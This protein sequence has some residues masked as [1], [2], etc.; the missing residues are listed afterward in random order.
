MKRNMMDS[1]VAWKKDA[2][3]RPLLLCGAR[4]VG[5][6]WLMKE[7][8]SREYDKTAY[9][10]FDR[11]SP[12]REV[13]ASETNVANL[14]NAIQLHVGFRII[15]KETLVIF[16]E[17]QECPGALASL[18]F[19]C[20]EAPDVDIIAA[21]S[22]LGL[23]DHVGT[24]FPVGKVDTL[25]LYPLSFKEFLGA[26]GKEQFAELIGGGDW[27]MLSAFHDECVRLLK[28]YFFIGGMP[29]VVD[30]YARHGDFTRVRRIQTSLLLGYKGDF[31]K[32]APPTEVRRIE[33]VW[34]S[35]PGQLSR[36]NKKFLFKDV[37]SGTRSRELEL[38]IQWLTEAGL[39]R[40]VNRVTK[41][42]LP[43]D[44]YHD[45]AFKGFV[46][47]VGLL[48][49]KTGLQLRTLLDGARIFEEF[50]GALT[51]QFVQQEIVAS[52]GELP[53][54][55]ASPRGDAEV[56]FLHQGTGDVVPVE[57]KASVNVKAKS[58]KTYCEKFR[59]PVAVRTSLMKYFS[60]MIGHVENGGE[61][62]LID[63][64]LY[65]ISRLKTEIEE[66]T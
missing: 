25:F 27:K 10:R 61:Y 8:G 4:Q 9:V 59:P 36:E 24:G 14:L 26:I 51:E 12:I 30:D 7:F 65:G 64:P 37:I 48:A 18:K 45:G 62:T 20:E 47:D 53:H 40:Q 6:T 22:Q 31:G 34:D 17:I 1:L 2:E 63:L 21:G 55:W 57:A 50:K 42:D 54:Y 11:A 56:D 39:M 33:A 28:L 43:L 19:F 38:S 44:A 60:Q 66:H 5:K 32:H 23:S 16:D 46:L 29:H 52:T 49:A 13:F 41:P 3:H 35:I 15:P 58:L